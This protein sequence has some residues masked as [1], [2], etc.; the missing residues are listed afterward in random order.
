MSGWGYRVAGV[1]TFPPLERRE[2]LSLTLAPGRGI[3][4]G[5][6]APLRLK[7]ELKA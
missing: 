4:L 7:I 5:L 3:R 6:M 2:S 1:S